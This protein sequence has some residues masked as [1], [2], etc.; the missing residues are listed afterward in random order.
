MLKIKNLKIQ[1]LS[2]IEGGYPGWILCSFQD[3]AGI[4]HLF[5]EKIPVVG[6]DDPESGRSYPYDFQVPCEILKEENNIATID[7]SR[8]YGIEARNGQT[9]FAVF[10]Y[11]L[12]DS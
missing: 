3:A 4:T 8:P 1:I 9:V 11:Q 7:L 12:S 2:L 5:E 6:A 10:F